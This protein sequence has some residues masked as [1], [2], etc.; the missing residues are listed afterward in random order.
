LQVDVADPAHVLLLAALA[1][2]AVVVGKRR[3]RRDGEDAQNR[4]IQRVLR[5]T[6]SAS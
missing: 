4:Y 5:R 3:T 1:D 2:A 6:S